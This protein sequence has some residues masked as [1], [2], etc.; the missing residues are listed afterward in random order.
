MPP[1]ANRILPPII[2]FG[3]MRKGVS[4]F[5]LLLLACAVC[6]QSIAQPI[7]PADGHVHILSPELIKIWKGMGIPF[8][9]PDAYYSDIQAILG[10]RCERIGPV[11]R[12]DVY[13]SEEFGGASPN[14][15]ALVEGEN[16][17]VAA[18]RDRYPRRI[19]AFCSLAPLRAYAFDE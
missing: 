17:F 12:A 6:S 4:L 10:N 7:P 14:E 11:S 16:S 13:S 3:N 1:I 19:R 2:A 15:R 9:R 5:I 8:S 18:A